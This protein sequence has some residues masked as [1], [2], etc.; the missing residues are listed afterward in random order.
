MAGNVGKTMLAV[1]GLSSAADESPSG[2]FLERKLGH[3]VEHPFNIRGKASHPYYTYGYGDYGDPYAPYSYGNDVYNSSDPKHYIYLHEGY[4]Y[5]V[6]EDHE[7]NAYLDGGAYEGKWESTW[8]IRIDM[9]ANNSEGVGWDG[10]RCHMEGHGSFW[11]A[12]DTNHSVWYGNRNA[13][14][15]H[16]IWCDPGPDPSV[17]YG[18]FEISY[19]DGMLEYSSY[20]NDTDFTWPASV[21][22]WALNTDWCARLCALRE[23]CRYFSW[24]SD[25]HCRFHEEKGGCHPQPT[26]HRRRY[27]RSRTY[28]IPKETQ[29]GLS[30]DHI[31]SALDEGRDYSFSHSGFC[32]SGWLSGMV[33]H[34]STLQ[35][36]ARW[37]R[38]VPVC[39]H[40]TFSA[41]KESCALYDVDTGCPSYSSDIAEDDFTSWKIIRPAEDDD[42]FSDYQ[43]LHMGFCDQG[44]DFLG[45]DS[46]RQFPYVYQCAEYCYDTPG[47]YHFSFSRRNFHCRLFGSSCENPASPYGD[48]PSDAFHGEPTQYGLENNLQHGEHNMQNGF[49]WYWEADEWYPWALPN[50]TDYMYSSYHVDSS[51]FSDRDPSSRTIRPFSRRAACSDSPPITLESGI[52]THCR[53]F[54]PGWTCWDSTVSN[55]S[56]GNCTASCGICT[57]YT[58]DIDMGHTNSHG[59]GCSLYNEMPVLCDIA[60]AYDD[61]DFTASFHCVVCGGGDRHACVP[62]DV[63][64]GTRPGDGI[65]DNAFVISLI[66]ETDEIVV[67]FPYRTGSEQHTRPRDSFV[68]HPGGAQCSYSSH[69]LYEAM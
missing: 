38:D 46:D 42:H 12:D 62:G 60:D 68:K 20:V 19:M 15:P 34:R 17:Q 32:A 3:E 2:N 5:G 33:N 54:F 4:C 40:F 37:C 52:V 43:L 25:L 26:S 18:H 39:G 57:G 35:A 63:V 14:I 13:E 48:Y 10:G 1:L 56:S 41:A 49:T 65:V 29:T 47:C 11:L 36:C 27:G 24:D 50:T 31:V 45:Y 30:I 16:Q 8:S 23:G 7:M 58:F 53:E 28:L 44:S 55:Y 66:R 69:E 64:R 21:D 61:D 22:A 59:Y 51:E 9:Y 67:E 6:A